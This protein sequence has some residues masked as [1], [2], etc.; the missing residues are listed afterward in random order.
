MDRSG[1]I[2]VDGTSL[3]VCQAGAGSAVSHKTYA[4][5]S[6]VARAIAR[7]LLSDV[8]NRFGGTPVAI[9]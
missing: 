6:R 2:A 5:E 3:T 8:L 9:L 4:S 7:F 1:Y